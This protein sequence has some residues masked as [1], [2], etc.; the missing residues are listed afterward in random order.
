[1]Y[2]KDAIR[3]SMNLA[4]QSVTLGPDPFANLGLEISDDGTRGTP[5]EWKGG[6]WVYYADL[7]S[8]SV[9]RQPETNSGKNLPLSHW[10]R[11]Y[12]WKADHGFENFGSWIS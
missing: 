11:V 8:F 6:K 9:N 7:D 2:T 12:N 3:F 5:T 10:L 4:E 1:M